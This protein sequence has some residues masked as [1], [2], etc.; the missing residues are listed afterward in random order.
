[1]KKNNILLA[2]KFPQKNSGGIINIPDVIATKTKYIIMQVNKYDGVEIKDKIEGEIYV[3]ND[4]NTKIK[5]VPYYITPNK[6]EQDFYLLLFHVYDIKTSGLYEAKYT[7]KD[8]IGNHIDSPTSNITII[9]VEYM[10]NADNEVIFLDAKKSILSLRTINLKEGVRLRAKFK[11]LVLY[12][13]IV[14]T[15]KFLG[16]DSVELITLISDNINLDSD[17]INN[18]YK[19]YITKTDKVNFLDVKYIIASFT[20]VNKTINQNFT[21]VSILND[22]DNV[23]IKVQTTKNI[24]SSLS[25]Y[26]DIRPYLTAVIYTGSNNNIITAQLTNAKFI[27]GTSNTIIDKIDENGVGYFHIYSDNVTKNSVLILNYADPVVAYKVPLDFGNWMSSSREELSYTYSSYGV[28]DG[29]C[30]CILLIKLLT[31]N[32]TGIYVGFDSPDIKINNWSNTLEIVNPDINKILVYELT[33]TKTVRS[34]FTINV[35]GIS[36]DQIKNTIVFVDPL[37]L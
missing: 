30:Q 15:A 23:N 7:V 21:Q 37:V 20:V 25:E 24:G 31:E 27:D 1:M 34:S 18:G 35:S 3:K 11:N 28:A 5:S 17:A 36:M 12:D 6:L 4:T 26:P 33:S 16:E 19:D 29:K 13:N 9:G 10:N 8:L 2:P 22:L 14:I 32:I